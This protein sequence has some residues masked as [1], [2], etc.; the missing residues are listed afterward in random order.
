MITI[1]IPTYQSER[2][3]VQTLAALIPGATAGL[4]MEVIVTDGGSIDATAEVADH[5]GCRYSSSGDPLGARL[6]EAA[7]TARAPWL[8]FLH[9]GCVLENEWV[10]DVGRFTEEAPMSG[11]RRAAA[12]RSTPASSRSPVT[13]ALSALAGALFSRI[14]PEQGLLISKQLYRSLGGHRANVGSPEADFIRRIGRRK[15]TLLGASIRS[16]T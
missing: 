8:L 9:P 7:T 11:P 2:S 10:A 6:K 14:R 15:I 4:V 5:A 1:I 16:L 3:L 12:F 13:D